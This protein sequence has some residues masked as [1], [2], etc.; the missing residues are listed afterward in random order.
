MFSSSSLLKIG[1]KQL[2]S[3]ASVFIE[4][5]QK[6]ISRIIK[7]TGPWHLSRSYLENER[8]RRRLGLSLLNC[9]NHTFMFSD[10]HSRTKIARVSFLFD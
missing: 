6:L 2:I 5:N 1:E 8:I 7:P 9:I 3:M 4:A 10:N